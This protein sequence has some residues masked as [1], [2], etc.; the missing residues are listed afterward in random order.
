MDAEVPA[1]DS[2]VISKPLLIVCVVGFVLVI[3]AGAAACYALKRPQQGDF[4]HLPEDTVDR[5]D[6]VR[7]R[8][9]RPHRTTN[10]CTVRHNTARH[11]TA[12]HRMG[13]CTYV[14][15]RGH[16]EARAGAS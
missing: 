14:R 8:M 4:H 3:L 12:P 13:A 16:V 5:N 9:R 11:G 10:M 15:A 1:G 2:L 7:A 6:I